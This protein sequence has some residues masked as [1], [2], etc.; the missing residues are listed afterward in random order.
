MMVSEQKKRLNRE[1]SLR[2]SDFG[3]ERE[4]QLIFL[5]KIPDNA[6]FWKLAFPCRLGADGRLMVSCHVGISFGKIES[7]LRPEEF[8]SG[9]TISTIM[10]PIHLLRTD[11]AYREWGFDVRDTGFYIH[12]EIIS[13]LRNFAFPFFEKYSDLNEVESE[14]NYEEPNHWFTLNSEQRIATLAAIAFSRGDHDVAYA[15]LEN[16]LY[17]RSAALPKKRRLLEAVFAHLRDQG[18]GKDSES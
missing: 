15:L 7:Y 1:L 5:R 11:T 13:D 10:K 17:E 12:D 8:S 16:A 4:K 3:F 2:L 6:C 14:L 9:L 18:R